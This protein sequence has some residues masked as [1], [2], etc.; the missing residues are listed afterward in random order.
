MQKY[1]VLETSGTADHRPRTLQDG[2]AAIEV[3]VKPIERV[4]YLLIAT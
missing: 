3:T 2:H 4:A 1:T